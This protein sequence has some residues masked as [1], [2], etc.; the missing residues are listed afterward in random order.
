MALREYGQDMHGIQQPTAEAI[1]A[2]RHDGDLDLVAF[3]PPG[4]ASA[5]IFH[6][7]NLDTGVTLAIMRQELRKQIF[8]HLRGTPDPEH[9]DLSALESPRALAEHCRI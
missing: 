5:T 8:D 2:R 6:E 4:Q 1:G 9:S 3:Q 7:V